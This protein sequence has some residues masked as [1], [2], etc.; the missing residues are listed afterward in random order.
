[1]PPRCRLTPDDDIDEFLN[2]QA[3]MWRG[4]Q[5]LPFQISLPRVFQPLTQLIEGAV[6]GDECGKDQSL[7]EQ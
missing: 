6:V 4:L 5:G 1:M 2:V 3:S 7:Q